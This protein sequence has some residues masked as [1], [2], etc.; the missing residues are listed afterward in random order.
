M[1]V[2]LIELVGYFGVLYG[3]VFHEF[4]ADVAVFLVSWKTDFV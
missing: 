3:S 1:H 4:L 2:V